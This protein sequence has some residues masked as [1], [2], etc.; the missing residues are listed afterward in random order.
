MAGIEVERLEH[1]VSRRHVLEVGVTA[2]GGILAASWLAACSPLATATAGAPASLVPVTNADE[3]LQRLKDGND[4]FSRDAS[5]SHNE[6]T[7]RR[8]ETAESQEPFAIVLGC[9]DSRVPPEL[10]FDQGL[11]D[12]FTVRVAGNSAADA[13]ILGSIEYAAEH[14]HSLI[15][16]VL[17]HETCGA[18]KA[19]MAQVQDG[20]TE[21]GHIPAVIEPIIAAIQA[22][23]SIP[24]DQRIEAAVKENVKRQGEA[25]AGSADILKGLV[26]AGKLKV[27]GAEYHLA[28]GKVEFLS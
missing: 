22:V 7:V 23:Q 12:I 3:A 24:A 18:V 1:V 11:G 10:V 27:V 4:R 28:T 2:A 20:P 8:A 26:D 25:I 13:G 6:D 19:A 21:H 17:G 14:L 5:I 15:V 16:V 9:A